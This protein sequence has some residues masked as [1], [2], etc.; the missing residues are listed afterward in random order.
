MISDKAYSYSYYLFVQYR[1]KKDLMIEDDDD[2]RY[3][4]SDLDDRLS[5]THVHTPLVRKCW[6]Y[7]GFTQNVIIIGNYREDD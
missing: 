4:I 7:P 1:N 2:L 5:S 3:S 6:R